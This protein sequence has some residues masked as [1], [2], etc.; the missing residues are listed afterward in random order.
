LEGPEAARLTGTDAF[1]AVLL[2][3]RAGT[4]QPLA[5]VR[6]LASAA[7]RAG[8]RFHS[9]SPATHCEDLGDTWRISTPHGTVT[10]PKV[11]IAT[12]VY[13]TGPWSALKEEQTPLPYF[14]LATAPLPA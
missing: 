7:I 1:P 12:D 9:R 3:H 11:I 8:S 10:T 13:S 14:N 5:Y 6:G 4:I 2:D